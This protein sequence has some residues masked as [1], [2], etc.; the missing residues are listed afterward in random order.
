V[1][2]FAFLVHPR[3]LSDVAQFSPKAAN[4]RPELVTKILEWLPAHLLSEITG[5]RSDA[6]GEEIKGEFISVPLL[7][8]Q[9]VSLDRR[10][11]VQRVVDAAQLALERG[12]QIVGLGGYTA[13][14]GGSGKIVSQRV[15][16]P[17][18]SGNCYTVATALDAL[19]ALCRILELDL[20]RLSVCVVGATG[21][22]GSVCSRELAR[23]VGWL[24]L[25]ARSRSR[26]SQLAEQIWSEGSCGVG[27]EC[28][29]DKAVAEA[30]VI[31]S[32]TSSGGG[33]IKL[34]TLKP[35]AIVCD[36]GV[37]HD[38]SQES[39]KSRPDVLVIEGGVVEA[40]GAPEFNFDF[41]YAPRLC[42]ACMAETMALTLA[43]RFE[44]FSVGRGLKYESVLEIKRL[45]TH[46]GFR[47]ASLRSFGAPLSPEDI[48]RYKEHRRPRR[49]YCV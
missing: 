28:D 38:V 37:P 6:T 42:M 11:V 2:K 45:A 44:N 41:G 3:D 40:P 49:F 26:L 8:H 14:V 4:R 36:I 12:A 48:E 7:P 9:I 19:L 21:S 30:D 16:V 29:I 31:V 23:R 47:L 18:T 32:A 24:T 34:E 25:A 43:G 10:Q 15:K 35:G 17:V 5:V 13:V 20:N 33:L 39:A 27:L 1:K 46:H 22:I